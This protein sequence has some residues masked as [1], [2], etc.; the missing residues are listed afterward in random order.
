MNVFGFKSASK[1]N[2]Y[3]K[4]IST[5]I[6]TTIQPT[7]ESLQKS[8]INDYFGDKLS[9]KLIENLRIINLSINGLDLGK[10]KHSLLQ[11][12][13]NLQDKGSDL[14]CLT[15]T[16]TNWHGQCFVQTFLH[17]KKCMVQKNNALCISDSSLPWN[18][19]YKPGA[20]AIIALGNISSAIITKGEDT[21]GLG[22]W[23]TVTMLKNTTKG[24]QSLMCTTRETKLLP[25]HCY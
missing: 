14:I 13:S 9:T 16:N 21:H 10:G 12:C 20:T 11:L 18:N 23:T 2:D 15:E 25:C 22:R 4:N 17:S 1:I 5:P 19:N 6:E 3:Q 8:Q 24:L 7:L